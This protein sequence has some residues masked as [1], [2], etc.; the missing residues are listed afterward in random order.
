VKNALQ[1]GLTYGQIA[2]PE[3]ESSTKELEILEQSA[4][5]GSVIK[6]ETKTHNLSLSPIYA[7]WILE[8]NPIARN[9]LLSC[10]ADGMASTFIWDCTAGRFNWYYELDETVYVLEGSVVIK[11]PMGA[12]R[13]L[14]VGDTILFPAGTHAEWNVES[15]VRKIAFCRVPMPRK[16]LLAKRLFRAVRRLVGDRAG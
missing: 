16:I 6:S 2:Q 3:A 12:C 10:S 7:A 9:K 5:H 11:D 13:R 4:R 1:P 14:S 15:Y 8:G